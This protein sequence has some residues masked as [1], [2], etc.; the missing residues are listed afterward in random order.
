MRVTVYPVRHFLL[1][2][3]A[4]SMSYLMQS[5]RLLLIC[6][7]QFL[8][9]DRLLI[10]LNAYNFWSLYCHVFQWPRR[11][12][13]LA[14]RFTGSSLVV[15]TI[16]F[17]TLKITLTIPHVTSHTKSS[18]SSS[19]HIGTSELKWSQ[20]RLSLSLMLRPTVSRPVCPGK[21]HPSGAYDQ[22]FISLWQLRFCFSGAP[23]LARGRVCHVLGSVD[24]NK[25]IVRIYKYLHFTCFTLKEYIYN[26]YKASVNPGQVQ[27]I[28][29][30]F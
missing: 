26:I 28:M 18:N 19:G 4:K 10:L 11:G 9:R 2:L 17:Y 23:S 8:A 1:S 12:F 27:Q 21:K 25:S 6:I 29:P 24:S 7:L 30:Y 13:G 16:S 5:M 14:N 15:A 22:I 20:I 3:P